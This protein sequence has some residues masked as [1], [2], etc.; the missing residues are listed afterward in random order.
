M[1]SYE[2]HDYLQEQTIAEVVKNAIHIYRTHFRKFF[3]SYFLLMLPATLLGFAG[4]AVFG[5]NVLLGF[6]IYET[7]GFVAGSVASLIV[8]L[9]VSDICLGEPPSVKRAWKHISLLLL[10]K[11]VL[12]TILVYSLFLI[13]TLIGFGLVILLSK[14][15]LLSYFV[16]VIYSILV[17]VLVPVLVSLFLFV[18]AIVALENRWAFGAMMR[19]VTLGYG[20]HLRNFVIVC[21]MFVLVTLLPI[22]LYFVSFFTGSEWAPALGICLYYIIG[23]LIQPLGLIYIILLYYDIRVRKEGYDNAALA[24]DLRH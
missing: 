20:Y 7:V 22:M 13:L 15:P 1:F 8:I 3:F 9:I 19:S 21:M 2:E 14:V 16:Y 23:F 17:I 12:T 10:V 18:P 6:A 5:D 11:L 24:E 4:V